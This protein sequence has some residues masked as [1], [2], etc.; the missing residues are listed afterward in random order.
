[1]TSTYPALRGRFGRTEYYVMTVRIADLV[2]NIRF[3]TEVD[4]WE[5]Y[6]LEEQFQ[7]KLDERRIDRDIAP[8]FAKDARRFSG[9]LVMATEASNGG[10][11][12]FDNIRDVVKDDLPA[13][14]N[15]PTQD[16]G[17]VT[18][19]DDSR[20]L[21]PLDGQHRARAF[22]CVLENDPENKLGDD[23]VVVIIVPFDKGDSRYIFNK[24]NKYAKPTSKAGKLIT[25]DDDA[26]AVITRKIIEG[27][28]I[29]RKLVNIDSSSLN[30]KSPEFT[31][32]STVYE[33]NR[34]LLPALPIQIVGRPETMN[35]KE[36]DDMQK[37]IEKE[38]RRLLSGIIE[39]KKVLGDAAKNGDSSRIELR[40][41]SILGLPVGQLSIV[42][43]YSLA[44]VLLGATDTDKDTLVKKLN[45]INWSRDNDMWNG[46]LIRTN[47]RV[48][49]GKRTARTAGRLIAH[50]LGAEI[51]QRD[52][53][54][55]LDQ[56]YGKGRAK[57]KKL[58]NR[59]T[60]K[61]AK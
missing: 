36:R 18:F 50:L 12:G 7:R 33:A 23:R 22:Q 41:R 37:D 5:T 44:C 10:A 43:G 34:E 40:K 24:I 35:D 46:I 48:M 9:A 20:H 54:F 55:I 25:D 58:P 11:M 17:F 45:R 49:Y 42:M 3:P 31:L 29:P 57:S 59:I 60:I 4:G 16:L 8:Y 38:W 30:K 14:Y 2:K 15:R 51:S 19:E 13:A 28:I 27:G 26:M 32:M 56:K 39:W 52:A 21:I 47:G 1:M 61:K 53:N 6:S